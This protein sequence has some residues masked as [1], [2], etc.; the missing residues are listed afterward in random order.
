MARRNTIGKTTPSARV[1]ALC[2]LEVT[3]SR[4]LLL[5]GALLL[6]L[7]KSRSETDDDAE[8]I[9]V[10]LC[11]VREVILTMGVY[12]RT[13]F[14]RK[15]MSID[16]FS[17]EECW[18]HF[19]FRRPDLHQLTELFQMPDLIRTKSR[20]TFRAEEALLVTLWRFNYPKRYVDM[21]KVFGRWPSHLCEIF[22]WTIEFLLQRFGHILDNIMWCQPF[23]S[24]FVQAI[25]RKDIPNSLY[26][27][28][29]FY[30]GTIRACARPSGAI[31]EDMFSGHTRVHG[32]KF[33]GVTLPNGLL[34]YLGVPAAG[35]HNDCFLVSE[36]DLV[37]QVTAI[38]A[39]FAEPL[40]SRLC[41][42][43]DSIFAIQPG[44]KRIHKGANLTD[45][46]RAENLA[47][48]SLRIT[49][50]WDFGVVANNWAFLNYEQ[51]LKLFMSPIAPFYAVGVLLTNCKTCFYG[52]TCSQ[53]F[54][55]IPPRVQFYLNL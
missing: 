32:L 47:M 16:D 42:F 5:C 25:A 50:E 39:D 45:V 41:L 28:W 30:D 34:G 1:A 18:C 10:L 51:N 23:V 46:Q 48:S 13:Q 3:R 9:G 37:E 19:R 20:Y 26:G 6:A 11:A 2:A 36:S 52:N 38:H 21:I 24:S 35:R 49:N 27:V 22:L 15:E 43:G 4:H 14:L 8:V 55:L 53:Y 54:G 7:G 44:M 31:Q 17:D 12:S 29:G 33:L 40:R